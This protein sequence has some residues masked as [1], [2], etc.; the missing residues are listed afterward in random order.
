MD[1]SQLLPEEFLTSFN[2]QIQI[3]FPSEEVMPHFE[4]W[5]ETPAAAEVQL[6]SSGMALMQSMRDEEHGLQELPQAPQ[7][8]LP[9]LETL[10]RGA[11]SPSLPWQLLQVLYVML[12][13]LW[14]LMG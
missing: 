2:H 5:W 14:V 9:K 3:G 4:P 1:V 6:S 10:H 11:L 7:E 8:P 13:D 12:A